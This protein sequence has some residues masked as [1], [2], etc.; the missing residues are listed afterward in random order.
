MFEAET[1]YRVLRDGS[2]D[3]HVAPHYLADRTGGRMVEVDGHK[4]SVYGSILVEYAVG[5]GH[6]SVGGCFNT[7]RRGGG[8]YST[9]G[10]WEQVFTSQWWGGMRHVYVRK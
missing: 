5:N 10:G 9:Q 7:T 3:V 8:E 2:T 6:V 4:S 1:F